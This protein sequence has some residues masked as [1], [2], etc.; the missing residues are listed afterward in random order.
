[1]PGNNQD[2]KQ[3]L[4]QLRQQYA[5]KLPERVFDIEKKWLALNLD[6]PQSIEY[7]N[8]TR[9]FHSLAGSGA[10]Y[11]FPQVTDLSREIEHI[12]LDRISNNTQGSEQ[13]RNQINDK[14]SALKMAATQKED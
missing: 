11:G 8:L 4:Q 9:E 13:I 5:D 1:M 14:L 7:E 6:D 2:I 3:K 12:L 10:S